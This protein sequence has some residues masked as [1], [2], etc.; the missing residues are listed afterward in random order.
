M[1]GS[2]TGVINKNGAAT[3]HMSSASV[4][5]IRHNSTGARGDI[6]STTNA[7]SSEKVVVFPSDGCSQKRHPQQE[8]SGM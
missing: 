6:V 5:G 4:A 3:I 1:E 8:N 2:A 7:I